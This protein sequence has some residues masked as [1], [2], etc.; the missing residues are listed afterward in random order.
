[1]K[2]VVLMDSLK[3]SLSSM[4]AGEA[5][6][7]GILSTI[8]DAEVS[9]YPFADGGEGSLE[10]FL[11]AD[12]NS[13]KICV[14]VSDPLGRP[15]DAYYGVLSDG[16]VVVEIAQAA[17]LCRL[18]PEERNPLVTSTRGVGELIRH[19]AENGYRSFLVAL[20]GSATNDC[21]L[22]MLR[23]LGYEFTDDQ[24][25][26]VAEGAQGLSDVC[27]VNDENVLSSLGECTFLIAGDVSNPLY[28]EQGASAVFGPQKGASKEDVIQMDLWMRRF[29]KIVQE[30]Y[31]NADPMA[32]GTGAAGGLGFAFRTFLGGE[33]HPGAQMLLHKTGLEQEIASSDLVITG[34]GR[35]DAQTVMGKAPIRIA[36]AAKKYGK[37]VIA[38]AGCLGDGAKECLAHGIDLIIPA[39][40]GPKADV[41]D[42]EHDRATE[43]IRC[44]A[45]EAMEQFRKFP[46]R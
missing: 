40:A 43:N 45:T 17:G 8:K 26:P 33:F 19:A 32:A 28:G 11:R 35:I 9:V 3:G 23:A 36:Q 39:V 24:N 34:E 12:G 20:G 1:M 30:R 41:K 16:T 2:I 5:V 31:P 7:E 15:V 10:A 46:R 4:E 29:A 27:S 22:G 37:P 42:L 18:S 13:R 21:G 6:R 25:Q 38:I 44:A 14:H